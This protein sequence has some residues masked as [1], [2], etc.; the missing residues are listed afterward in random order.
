MS[1]LLPKLSARS[2]FMINPFDS[3]FEESLLQNPYD[4]NVWLRYID[5]KR[6]SL[7][8]SL[9]SPPSSLSSSSSSSSLKALYTLYERSLK[10]FPRSYKLW[11]MYLQ[12]RM[13]SLRGRPVTDKRYEVTANTFER[14]LVYMNKMP[15][16]WMDYL[17]LLSISCKGTLTR[18]TYDRAL[19]ALPIT[20][21]ERIWNSYIDWVKKFGVSTS[22]IQVYRRILMFDSTIHRENFISYLEEIENYGECAIQIVACLDDS[23][24]TSTN[25][26]TKHQLWM[27]L[28][29]I[30]SEHPEE[31]SNVIDVDSIIRTGI[32]RFTDEVG[33]LWCKLAIYYTRLGMF[34]TSRDVYEEA[35]SKVITVRDFSLVYD[36]YVR[37]EENVLSVKM[38][39]L[40][41]DD[42]DDDDDVTEEED[43]EQ[44]NKE[45]EI[46]VAR[47]EFLFDQ[48]L[49][50]LNAVKLRQNP[51]NC[52]EWSNR[53]RL[54]TAAPS[55]QGD[56]GDKEVNDKS[57]IIK[58]LD[59]LLEA[60][61]T[62]EP[63]NATGKLSTLWISLAKCYNDLGDNDGARD[64]FAT[65]ITINFKSV[66]E[67]AAVWCAWA[68]W[69]MHS[70]RFEKALCIMTQAI[71]APNNGRRM[72][73]VMDE[74]NNNKFNQL[75]SLDRVHRSVRV[76]ALYLDLEESFGTKD[77]CCAAYDR[78]FEL[79]ILTPSMAINYASYLEGLQYFEESFK[80]FEKAID[81][82][83]GTF[84][85]CKVLWVAYIE[86]FIAR[87][88]GTK[89]ERLRDL[90]EQSLLKAPPEEAA[91]L[92][93]M[94][95]KTEE[96]FGLVRHAIA[97]LERSIQVCA[98]IHKIEMYKLYIKKVEKHFGVTRTRP[99]YER[100]ITELPDTDSREF[101]IMYANMETTLGEIDRARAL[102]IHAS[103]F[104]DPRVLP[105]YWQIWRSFEETHGNE[106]TFREMLRIKHTVE[107]ANAQTHYL[108]ET[109][110]E[111]G[112]DRKEGEKEGE[113]RG[114]NNGKHAFIQSTSEVANRRCNLNVVQSTNSDTM[115]PDDL[116]IDE[117]GEDVRDPIERSI[118]NSVFGSLGKASTSASSDV[119]CL[120]GALERFREGV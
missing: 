91:N 85:H 101:C 22:I 73:T 103:Q 21:H 29:D 40:D 100:A 26:N 34:E 9:S 83:G 58:S 51:G 102:Y 69:E 62:V 30:C 17:A 78:A 84:P 97:V 75:S 98:E 19:Q 38:G 6:A 94:Y 64:T 104:A 36:S 52:L 10:H 35:I 70:K 116:D 11:R 59:I 92:F 66:D 44:L 27:H 95:V 37:F 14:S 32:D 48:R 108:A 49:L 89:L 1:T 16:I 39:I 82:F 43:K 5:S 115:H 113:E 25:G 114:G 111:G 41:D 67:L 53:A 71:T 4:L 42:D 106:E 72:M 47:L 63:E 79:K 2:H 50:L 77:T 7:S 74:S 99:V 107:A 90:H 24:F 76:W 45:I 87:Y 28:C 20:Q 3:R 13:I 96:D 118:P 112:L 18:K 109:I 105:K 88:K 54:V 23:N 117:D 120:K 8:S 93:V 68:E 81:L 60:V 31:C 65:A 15:V 86:K 80:I 61:E 56:V 57:N 46:K 55:S 110:R 12:E 119:G 33:G